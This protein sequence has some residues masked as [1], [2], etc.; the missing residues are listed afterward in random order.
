MKIFTLLRPARNWFL[1]RRTCKR[2][3]QCDLTF[4][5]KYILA[6]FIIVSAT[7][8][9]QG[10]TGFPAFAD[11]REI[12]DCRALLPGLAMTGKT[13]RRRRSNALQ[14]GQVSHKVATEILP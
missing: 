10:S 8:M 3:A 6:M 1:E 14:G 13:L 2:Y 7:S 12:L 11:D 5:H 9:P 4:T